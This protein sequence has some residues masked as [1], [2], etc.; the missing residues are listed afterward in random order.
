M[1][2]FRGSAALQRL[3][4]RLHGDDK[5]LTGVCHGI[6]GFVDSLD[7]S[8]GRIVAGKRVTG[9]SN[10]EDTLA[11][12]RKLMPFLLEDALIGS[13]GAYHKNFL[14]FTAR[15]EVDGKL[16][17]GQNPASARAVGEALVQKLR[18]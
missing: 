6:S 14:P 8:G 1:F 11:G 18:P 12:T 7:A 15:V 17:T 9:F 10:F 16:I 4:T 13:G 5:F 3:I 2:D